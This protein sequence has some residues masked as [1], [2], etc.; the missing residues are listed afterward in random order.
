MKKREGYKIGPHK[1]DIRYAYE[2]LLLTYKI[3]IQ[4]EITSKENPGNLVSP[5]NNFL[6]F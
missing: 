6:F 3:I 5:K 4:I 2:A 1:I